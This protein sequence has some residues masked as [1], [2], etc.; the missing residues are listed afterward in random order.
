LISCGVAASAD[1]AQCEVKGT[2]CGDGRLARAEPDGGS[3]RA[4]G[5]SSRRDDPASGSPSYFG[6]I[7]FTADGSWA[8]AWKK[9]SRAE[10]EA[11]VAKRCAEFGRGSCKVVAF[12]GEQFVGLATFIGRSGRTRWKL[13]FTGGGVTGPEAQRSAMDRCNED[14]R[15]RAVPVAHLGVRRRTLTFA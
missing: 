12:P 5:G 8:T 13:S 4:D 1:R 2:V 9:P 11:D 6:A 15:T 7:G 3:S 14:N 10:A